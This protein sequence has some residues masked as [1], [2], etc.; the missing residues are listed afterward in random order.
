MPTYLKLII[1]L[2]ETIGLLIFSFIRCRQDFKVYKEDKCNGTNRSNLKISI[3]YYSICNSI[4]LFIFIFTFPSYMFLSYSKLILITIAVITSFLPYVFIIK[5]EK[6]MGISA[7]LF[8]LFV[9]GM[10]STGVI[11]VFSFCAPE[12]FIQ[13]KTCI[14]EETNIEKINPE[15]NLTDKSKIGHYL[16]DSGDIDNY[17][18]FYQNSDSNWCKV[19]ESI[20]RENTKELSNGESS[21]VEKYVTTRTIWNLELD[22]SD[23]NYIITEKTVSYNLYYNPNELIEITD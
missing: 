6:Y 22:E 3:I 20:E 17:I 19:D 10:V 15:I 16:N 8:F 18:F 4:I 1:M 12:S 2:G 14:N 9:L 21:Y 13:F 11:T 23:D 5:L 7:I